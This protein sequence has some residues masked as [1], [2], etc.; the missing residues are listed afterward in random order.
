MPWF[1]ID[2]GFWGHPRRLEL[3]MSAIGLWAVSGSWAARH[4]TDGFVPRSIMPIL[5]GKPRDI[6]ALTDAGMWLE[7]AN[8]W[9]FRDWTHY[10][11]T[12]VQVERD[13]ELAR[14]RMG[15][16]RN[17][18]KEIEQPPEPT[19][20]VTPDVRAN[21]DGS[22]TSHT[23]PYQASTSPLSTSVEL[24]GGG[25]VTREP[26]PPLFC[27]KHPNGHGGPCGACADARKIHT[28]WVERETQRN[29]D[30]AWAAAESVKSCPNHCINGW[31]EDAENNPIRKCNHQAA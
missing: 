15:R 30:R 20:D 22:S 7:Q 12:K 10:Q 21:F 9:Q 31:I 29:L 4:L 17:G 25:S 6:K 28:A 13:R 8:G 5:G 27:K 23:K 24:L 11:K 18:Y 14:K 16:S 1:R 26:E 3:S 19:D 2:D